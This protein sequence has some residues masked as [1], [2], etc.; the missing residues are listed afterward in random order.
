MTCDAREL[1]T[2]DIESF[3]ETL[4]DPSIL[5][6]TDAHTKKDAGCNGCCKRGAPLLPGEA[7]YHRKRQQNGDI[8]PNVGISR[9][10]ISNCFS[11]EVGCL[12]ADR[13]AIFCAL[14][15]FIT[16]H[17]DLFQKG[18]FTISEEPSRICPASVN[19]EAQKNA[20]QAM[21]I[22]RSAIE[23]SN[24]LYGIKKSIQFGTP[25]AKR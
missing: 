13:R 23:E 2:A 18:R 15:P 17:T 14:F 5:E 11:E 3:Y 6:C 22:V 24:K 9:T 25:H 20:E 12:I 10:H 21:R 16:W 4:G 1:T 19:T 7:A 8:K